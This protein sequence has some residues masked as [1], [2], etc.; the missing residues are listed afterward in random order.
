MD[1]SMTVLTVVSA[2]LGSAGLWKFFE[3]KISLRHKDNEADR[4]DKSLY[5][6]DLKDRVV[7]L[8]EELRKA[9]EMER[10][11]Q[12]EILSLT[13]MVAELSTKVE[14]MGKTIDEL[15]T[16]NTILKSR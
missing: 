5:R 4:E 9:K 6:N 2:T 3:K 7:K 12:K 13:K 11:M 14:F 15:K 10:L 1:T 16:E 8:E